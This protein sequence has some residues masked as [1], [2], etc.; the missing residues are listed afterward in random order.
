MIAKG[1]CDYDDQNRAICVA[2]RRATVA[3]QY[4]YV[5]K[6][7]ELNKNSLW[8]LCLKYGN[9]FTLAE[10]YLHIPKILEL[11]D[12]SQ[13]KMSVL[14]YWHQR[15]A[16]KLP[17]VKVREDSIILPPLNTTKSER[18]AVKEFFSN[19]SICRPDTSADDDRDDP[20]W[21]WDLI[22]EQP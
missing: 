12:L 11:F 16:W 1:T 8:K 10:S 5:R 6:F 14:G 4:I 19:I 2:Y 21:Q 15:L 7:Y 9:D 13:G 20:H 22:L 18:A 17:P 3:H